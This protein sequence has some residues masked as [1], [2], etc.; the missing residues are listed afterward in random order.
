MELGRCLAQPDIVAAGS[1]TH[2]HLADL[3]D[4]WLDKIKARVRLFAWEGF[5]WNQSGRRCNW[6]C[7]I[8]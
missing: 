7:D 3:H 2:K 5:F 1:P 4:T 8:L 6:V